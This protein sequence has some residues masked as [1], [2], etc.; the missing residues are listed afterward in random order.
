MIKEAAF[1]GTDYIMSGSD[2]GHIFFW[3][4]KTEE[5]VMLLEGDQH[6]V[7][8][9]QPHPTL[10]Y[11]ATSGIDYDIKIWAPTSAE[12]NFDTG[13]ADTVS[14]AFLNSCAK[15]YSAFRYSFLISNFQLRT[16]NATMLEETRDTITVPASFMIRM[17]ARINQRRR[18]AARHQ[19]SQTE[20]NQETESD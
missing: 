20:H 13:Y 9:I 15:R 4:R 10:P 2:C 3:D 14:I 18:G 7:N 5:L 1:W 17:I 6:V 11:L 12:K 16:R 19:E 8:C